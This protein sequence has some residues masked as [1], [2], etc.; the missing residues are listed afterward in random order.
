MPGG[1][2]NPDTLRADPKALQFV[3]DMADADKIVTALCHG[4]WVIADAGLI[5]GKR[6]TGWWTIRRDL[7]NAGATFLDEPAV[8]DGNVVTARAPIDLAAF[9]H[10]ID[11]LLAQR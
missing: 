7:E 10:A 3:K 4:P 11:G 9:V 5:R 1:A 6:V 8:V 2:W